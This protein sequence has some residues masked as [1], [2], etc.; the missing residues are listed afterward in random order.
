[1]PAVKNVEGQNVEIK[2][3]DVWDIRSNGRKPIRTKGRRE[4]TST[5][6]IRPKG[7]K[8]DRDNRS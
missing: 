7:K 4:K 3:N 2:K 1:M 5:G 6:T 8:V